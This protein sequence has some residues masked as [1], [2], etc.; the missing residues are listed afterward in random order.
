MSVKSWIK[1]QLLPVLP[2][3]WIDF[4]ATSDFRK[5]AERK[6][7]VKSFH[8]VSQCFTARPTPCAIRLVFVSIL[9]VYFRHPERAPLSYLIDTVLVLVRE[10]FSCSLVMNIYSGHVEVS[11][12]KSLTVIGSHQK[13]HF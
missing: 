9:S 8:H 2:C 12:I 5:R 1:C 4:A 13:I 7:D 10:T 6:Q 3:M 11:M